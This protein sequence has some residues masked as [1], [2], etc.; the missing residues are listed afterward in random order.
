MRGYFRRGYTPLVKPSAGCKRCSLYGLC[1]Q[2]L[3]KQ[4]E[5]ASG[6]IAARLKEEEA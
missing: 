2:S 4:K 3:L 5:S 1:L 6:Y